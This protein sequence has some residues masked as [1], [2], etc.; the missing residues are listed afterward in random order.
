M[1]LVSWNCASWKK[2][3][4]HINANH[5]PAK[6]VLHP[7]TT[8]ESTTTA[9]ATATATCGLNSKSVTS[10]NTT[11][12]GLDDWLS[13]LQAD[14]LCLQEVKI[15]RTKV[16]SLA[17]LIGARSNQYDAFFAC[18]FGDVSSAGTG[19]A[20]TTSSGGGGGGG[21]GSSSNNG[22]RTSTATTSGN[23]SQTG[24]GLNGVAT[25][26][27]KGRTVRASA[28]ELD[29]GKVIRRHM[30]YAIGCHVSCQYNS[31][32]IKSISRFIAGNSA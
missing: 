28:R 5:R 7:F 20:A 19:T 1:F 25:F 12:A 21:S 30:P 4:E 15:D 13:Q 3:L 22:T 24:G 32:F 31:Q 18:P 9:T 16:E 23:S 29:A 10:T 11:T 26:V 27:R 17:T 8:T 6:K 2:T 14:I